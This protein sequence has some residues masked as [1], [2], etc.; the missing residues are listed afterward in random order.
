MGKLIKIA[1]FLVAGILIY[2]YFFGT[3]EEKQQSKEVFK[4]TGDALGAA[5]NILKSEKQKFDAGKY[6]KVL[7]QLGDAYKSIRE[8]AQYVDKKVLSRL[9]ELEQ[10]KAELQTQLD[11]IESEEQAAPPPSTSGKNRGLRSNASDVSTKAADQ[12]QRKERLQRQLEELIRDTDGL[13]K[14]AQE[15]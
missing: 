14:Q 1:L 9:D 3:S 4:K 11:S 6:D 7:G 8:R 15:Q 13:L 12:Q 2:N 5:W 10:R